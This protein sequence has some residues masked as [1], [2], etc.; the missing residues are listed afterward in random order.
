MKSSLLL[1][2]MLLLGTACAQSRH[3]TPGPTTDPCSYF[4]HNS[5][6]YSQC[7]MY[8]VQ[9]LNAQGFEHVQR[10]AYQRNRPNPYLR[11]DALQ[12]F[13]EAFKKDHHE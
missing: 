4:E 12:S 6:R 11:Y 7:L 2:F 1:S 13:H 3:Y 10:Q 9:D 8:R 5:A